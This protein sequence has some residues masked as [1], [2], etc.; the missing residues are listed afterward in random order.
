MFE[1]CKSRI[2]NIIF[3][4]V[5]KE[6]MNQLRTLHAD[7]YNGIEQAIPGTRSYHQFL[8]L[9]SD[10][11]G[12][13]RC[14]DD[15]EFACVHDFKLVFCLDEEIVVG[16]YAAVMYDQCWWISLLM[17]NDDEEC[18]VKV[19]FMHPKGPS[20]YYHWPQRD[21]VCFIPHDCVLKI[22]NVPIATGSAR[23]Y[24]IPENDERKIME[25]CSNFLKHN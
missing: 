17:E 8:P 9:S 15:D 3:K 4:F 18:D 11:I 20:K 1:F 6:D 5:P 14:S 2:P 10:R 23:N 13:K 7:R 12:C 21:D 25:K 24:S 16:S 19:K 22:I